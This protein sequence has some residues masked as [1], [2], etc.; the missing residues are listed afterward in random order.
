[1]TIETTQ[2]DAAKYLDTPESQ[3]ELI[4]DALESGDAQYLAHA[5]GVVAR[6]KGMSKVARDAG[7]TREGLYKA[8][9]PDGD[10]RLTTF[11]GVLKSL[12][13]RITVRA[14]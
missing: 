2:F 7:I 5:L 10:P 4:S 8:L 3:A 13:L 12:G 6:A 1:M 14:A 11:L 9:S